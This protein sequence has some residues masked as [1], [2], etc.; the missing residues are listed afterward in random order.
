MNVF[1]LSC[2]WLPCLADWQVS[3]SRLLR[4]P[5]AAKHLSPK[6][7]WTRATKHFLPEKDKTRE[8]G[9]ASR[10]FW[11]EMNIVRQIT[12]LFLLAYAIPS[13]MAVNLATR[14]S[15]SDRDRQPMKLCC[16]RDVWLSSVMSA[17]V[18]HVRS[19]ERYC[20]ETAE[21]ILKLFFTVCSCSSS[22]L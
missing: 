1:S 2:S 5:D 10:T 17:S 19:H 4:G 8:R 7:L 14:R 21:H 18:R 15:S 16:V 22:T 13:C 6:R 3:C 12:G 20:V 11:R 9:S